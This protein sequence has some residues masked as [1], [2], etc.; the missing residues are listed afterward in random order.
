LQRIL[1]IRF[2]SIGDIVLTT[3]VIRCIKEQLPDAE[4]HYLTKE[5]FYPVIKAN[6]Y[7]SHVHIFK[8]DLGQTIR[9][10]KKNRFNYIV[11]L[12]K[13][14]R[15][16]RV[17]MALRKPSGTF[18]KLN[19]QKWLMVNMK[20]NNLP[21][22]HIVDRY[23]NAL[24]A[25]DVTNDG[26]GLE[27]FIPDEDRLDRNDLPP[28][29]ANGFVAFVTGGMHYTK[30]LPDEKIMALCKKIDMPVILMGGR[31]D[32]AKAERITLQCE[33]KIYNGCG[34][35]NI[36]QSASILSM[37][38]KVITNDTGLMHIAAAFKKEIFSVWGN[39]IPE[40]GMYPYMPGNEK[41]SHIMEVKDLSCR[42]CSKIGYSRCPKKH[43]RCMMDIDIE[44][45]AS[46][47]NT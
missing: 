20:I 1:I 37:A 31:D 45:I 28:S 3:P 7:I 22:V 46:N 44:A 23:F 8:D 13:N 17:K 36:N 4:I 32:K 43:F 29:H 18:N 42:P 12:H 24:K 47:I 15:S 27:Y 9:T 34:L 35:Y 26:R 21:D 19:R 39:T 38:D 10:L 40:F 41:N 25:L 11:D 2:S 33:Q 14:L 5:K 16:F 30:M 6:P